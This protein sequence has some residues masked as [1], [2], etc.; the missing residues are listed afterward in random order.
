MK[1]DS[2]EAETNNFMAKVIQ[3]NP[4]K[5]LLFTEAFKLYSHLQA[6]LSLSLPIPFLGF[7][8][9]MMRGAIQSF[10]HIKG[11]HYPSNFLF[12]YFAGAV[13]KLPC[14]TF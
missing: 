10:L 14:L 8:F 6:V 11:F 3:A 2:F 13:L 7:I 5:C 12:Q 1:Y 9:H 4:I